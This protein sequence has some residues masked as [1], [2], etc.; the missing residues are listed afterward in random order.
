MAQPVDGTLIK[1]QK[2][3]ETAVGDLIRQG[4][5]FEQILDVLRDYLRKR[6]ILILQY[7]QAWIVAELVNKTPRQRE[8]FSTPAEALTY[9]LELYNKHE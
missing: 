6:N 4:V 2:G 1:I 9:A 3:A 7:E 8:S 5:Y